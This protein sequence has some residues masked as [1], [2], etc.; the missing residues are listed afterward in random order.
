[1]IEHLHKGNE[2][3]DR[4]QDVDE[5]PVLVNR[6]RIEEELSTGMGRVQEIARSIG[7]PVE[8]R[9]AGSGFQNE[10]GDD[11]LHEETNDD[12]WP[13]QA[14]QSSLRKIRE[15]KNLPGHMLLVHRGKIQAALENNKT[16]DGDSTVAV[17]SSLF[18]IRVRKV[19]KP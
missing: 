11:L 7:D 18:G 4:G 14:I 16:E 3:D 2:E 8:D 15:F 5:E 6:V 9:I 12:G 17:A 19:L 13:N 10:Q 1:V